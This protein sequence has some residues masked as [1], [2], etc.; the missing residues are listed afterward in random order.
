MFFGRQRHVVL[1]EHTKFCT[2]RSIHDMLLQRLQ[3]SF[4]IDGVALK[5]FQSYLSGRTQHVRRGTDRWAT[6]RL[7]CGVP[8]GSV[9]GP[10]LF[11]LY[12]ADLVS[13][14]EE[15]GRHRTCTLTILKYTAPV[16]HPL[17]VILYKISMGALMLLVTGCRVIGFN[18]TVTSLSSCGSLQPDV[19]CSF[20]LLV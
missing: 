16:R 17:S 1:H 5:W 4:G 20:P 10:I 6:V 8:Q 2:N 14:I 19:N 15:H 9:L 13:V 11:I 3:I 18:L 12:T 7:I